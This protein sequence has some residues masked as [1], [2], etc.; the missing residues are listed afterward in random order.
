MTYTI[1]GRCSRTGQLGI[2]L[3]TW[4][5]AVGGYCP[6]IKSN[7]AALSSQAAV[8]PR[9]GLLAMRLLELGFSPDG[10][11]EELRRQDPY[12]EYRQVGIVDKD[13]YSVAHTGTKTKAW[14]GHITG[15]GYLAMGNGLDSEK[16]AQAM[17]DTFLNTLE[18]DLDER[19]LR[20]LEA[21]REAG[22]QQ[23]MH[24]GTANQ[25]RSA[26]L[27]VYEREEYALMDLRVDAHETAI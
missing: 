13:G 8:N 15:E 11:L 21:G 16:V 23:A 18:L 14:T 1:I 19:L 24:P 4:S 9:L 2:G 7:L 12:Y 5:L 26:G 6:R 10:V 27:I 25:D 22:G 3:T 20:C 17:S